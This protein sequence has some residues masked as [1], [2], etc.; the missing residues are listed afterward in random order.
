[1]IWFK[2]RYS[3]KSISYLECMLENILDWEV[4]SKK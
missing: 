4:E 2:V 3:W 1:M